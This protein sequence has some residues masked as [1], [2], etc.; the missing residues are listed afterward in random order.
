MPCYEDYI[1]ISSATP[2]RSKLYV[3]SLPGVEVNLLED[4]KTSDQ[5]DYL[6]FWDT[7]YKRAWDNLVA[8]VSNA[9]TDKFFVDLKLLARETSEF[10]ESVNSGS[11]LA[12]VRIQVDLPKY[13]RIHIIDVEVH[14]EADY[15][16]PDFE[17]KIFRD[18]AQG[19]LLL[20]ASG[21]VS[22]GHSVIHIDTDFEACE[23]FVGYDPSQYS[24]RKTEN[25]HFPLDWIRWSKLECVWPCFLGVGSVKQVNG[26][27]LNVKFL[28]YCSV[29]KFVC[30]NLNL[31]KQAFLWRI[32]NEIIIERRY[33]NTV[34]CFTAMTAERAEELTEFYVNTYQEKLDNA[35]KGH[36]ITEDP[37]CFNCKNSVTHK[38]IV[39]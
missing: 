26:G 32:G 1:T 15:E 34:N 4:L 35:I 18:D 12:G 38:T 8:D 5:D 28:V 20:T 30:E 16:S 33:G 24:I 29:E 9:L 3:T 11:S 14:S 13:A 7:V 17:V 19:E 21:E 36:R 39:P 25:K 31:F 2:S 27:G 22:Q 23:L 37:F 10:L 6:A